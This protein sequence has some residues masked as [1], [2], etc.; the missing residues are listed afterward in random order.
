MGRLA[1]AAVGF[2]L[3]DG[4]SFAGRKAYSK[5]RMAARYGVLLTVNA[6]LSVLLLRLSV[7][8]LDIDSWLARPVIDLFII[9]LAFLGSRQWVFRMAKT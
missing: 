7:E 1:G 9:A 8:G 3:H 6:V 5:V 4:Y 2:V